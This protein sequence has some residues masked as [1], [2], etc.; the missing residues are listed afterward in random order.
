VLSDPG[1][2]ALERELAGRLLPLPIDQ[3]YG[4]EDMNRLAAIVINSYPRP[5]IKPWK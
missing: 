1:A 5:A 2:P 3:R 4:A